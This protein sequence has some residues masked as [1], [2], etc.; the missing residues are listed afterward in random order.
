LER[1]NEK[2]GNILHVKFKTFNQIQRD[3]KIK[4][5]SLFLLEL[6]IGKCLIDNISN[7]NNHLINDKEGNSNNGNSLEQEST[8]IVEHELEL[9][10]VNGKII[11]HGK[12]ILLF[13]Y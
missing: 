12:Q 4:Q 5:I 2:M 10:K 8:F 9:G 7:E 6:I 11:Y 13:D 3:R 1:N